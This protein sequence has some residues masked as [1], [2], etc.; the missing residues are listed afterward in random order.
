MVLQFPGFFFTATSAA[1]TA[2]SGNF[3]LPRGVFN[4]NIAFAGGP[5]TVNLTDNLGNG[6]L[7]FAALA[8]SGISWIFD[9]SGLVPSMVG[10]GITQVDPIGN[11]NPRATS[12]N[13]NIGAA[14]VGNTTTI[15]VRTYD[16]G[17]SY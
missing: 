17:Q 8:T 4:V 2:Q 14:G 3:G 15:N 1:N 13:F 10:S 16:V 5:I 6:L 9:S 12:I 7:S 11:I